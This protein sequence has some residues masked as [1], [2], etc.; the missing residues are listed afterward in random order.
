MATTLALPVEGRLP[1]LEGATGW[2]NTEPLAAGALEGKVVL[3][4]FCTYSCVNWLRTLP[5]VRAWDERYRDDGL[6]VIGAHSP[7]FPFEHDVD[8]VRPA[9]EAMGVRYAIAIDNDFAIWRAFENQYWPALYLA[10]AQ[11][12]IRY[13]HFGEGSYESSEHAIQ[14]LLGRAGGTVTADTL[15]IEA[16]AD[17]ATLGSPETYV[18]YARGE[19]FAS[20]EKVLPDQPVAYSYPPRLRLNEW[21]LSGDWAF[22]SQATVLEGASGQISYR[23]HARDVNL[24]LRPRASGEAVR[25]RLLIDGAPPAGNRGLDVDE[26]G[27]GT[28]T[29]ARLYQLVRQ[30]GRVSDATVAI[31]FLDPGVRAYVFTFG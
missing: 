28:V 15:G 24:V 4:Q 6:V 29:E 13:R 3:V 14:Q 9:L 16:G 11:G 27:L 8:N 19:R 31:T 1:S 21:A 26:E 30:R 12:A 20:P 7:E 22:G 2:L 5:Y 23:F 25:F 17:L 18:G 10:D